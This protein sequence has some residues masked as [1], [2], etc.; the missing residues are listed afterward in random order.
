MSLK[1]PQAT[2]PRLNQNLPDDESARIGALD[3]IPDWL[4][5]TVDDL[6]QHLDRSVMLRV[7]NIPP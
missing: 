3:I 6:I 4:Q 7:Q 1:K 2:P 5:S